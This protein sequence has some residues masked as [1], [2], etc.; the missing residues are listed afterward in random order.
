[1][2]NL[3]G[4]ASDSVIA[5]EQPGY[6]RSGQLPVKVL[7]TPWSLLHKAWLHWTFPGL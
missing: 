7:G 2:P 3:P 4:T 5:N 1:L 6:R